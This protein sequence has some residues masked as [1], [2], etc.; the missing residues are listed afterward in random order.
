MIKK[1]VIKTVLIK[2][3]YYPV[4][5]YKYNAEIFTSLDGGK[6]FWYTGNG[7]FFR[8]RKEAVAYKKKIEKENL[9]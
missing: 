7:K 3:F 1:Q 2:R 5:G 4:N 8:T 9:V 6:T